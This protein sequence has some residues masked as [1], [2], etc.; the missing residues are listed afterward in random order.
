[1]KVGT[2]YS[3]INRLNFE[4]LVQVQAE[5]DIKKTTPLDVIKNLSNKFAD[6]HERYPDSKV[7]DGGENEDSAK[8]LSELGTLFII[9]LSVILFILILY[10]NSIIIPVVVMIAIPFALVGVVFAL[11]THGNPLSFMSVLGL[12]SLA[13]VIVSNTLVLVSFING[14]RQ[15][16]ETLMDSLIDGAVVRLRPIF[17]TAGTTV[18]TLLP[19][20]YGLGGKDYM[21]APLALVF[22]YGLLFAMFITLILVPCFYHV[23]EDVKGLASRM[24]AKIGINM[25]PEIYTKV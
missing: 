15:Q 5:V 2:S 18:L 7:H 4:R 8:S 21:V 24:L 14:F 17:L 11:Y 20:V 1:M 12:F 22:A 10:Y 25:N 23:A 19:T 13:G 16:G 3:Q 6:I 9:A